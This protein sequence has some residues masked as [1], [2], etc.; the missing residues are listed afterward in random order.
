MLQQRRH[1]SRLA[2]FNETK[3]L[4]SNILYT[5]TKRDLATFLGIKESKHWWVHPCGESFWTWK[6][7]LVFWSFHFNSAMEGKVS[8][9]KI[10]SL[11]N[12]HS[13]P[14]EEC[15][16]SPISLHLLPLFNNLQKRT[17]TP[18]SYTVSLITW[19]TRRTSLHF[20][21]SL[22]PAYSFYLWASVSSQLKSTQEVISLTAL[23]F[24]HWR[25]SS[26]LSLVSL[27]RLVFRPSDI[28]MPY[29]NAALRK[30]K[31]KWGKEGTRGCMTVQ[32][33][34]QMALWL[35]T[36][37]RNVSA[38]LPSNLVKASPLHHHP[39]PHSLAVFSTDS[40]GQSLLVVHILAVFL[41]GIKVP[42]A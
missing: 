12:S 37:F 41:L 6:W 20:H 15:W 23:I 19:G 5:L 14:E 27:K 7:R 13:A 16:C 9:P 30:I 2:R 42:A 28:L 35:K 33:C 21:G 38:T 29:W 25:S 3:W 32:R 31:D 8:Q 17:V 39:S 11:S 18:N 36:L 10:S 26:A 4:Y 1:D 22:P 40:L 34:S 24:F